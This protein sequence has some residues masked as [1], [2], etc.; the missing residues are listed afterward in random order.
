[1]KTFHAYGALIIVGALVMGGCRHTWQGA[2]VDA[3]RAAEKTGQGLEKAGDKIEH[4]GD[5]K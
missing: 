2:K 5:K 1:M 4:A 3:Q